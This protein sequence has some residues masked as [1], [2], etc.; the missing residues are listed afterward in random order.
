[1]S[2]ESNTGATEANNAPASPD[3]NGSDKPNNVRDLEPWAQKLISD[4][5]SEAADYR[6]R[7]RET[8][9]AKAALEAELNEL[10]PQYQ[11]LST[12]MEDLRLGSTKLEVA[13]DA[14][15]GGEQAVLFADRLRGTTREELQADA[16]K[17]LK[18]FQQPNNR[19]ATDPTQ[20]LGSAP[21]P[22]ID[23][24]MGDFFTQQLG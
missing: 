20:G 24:I 6:T 23:E 12:E 15:L 8:A 5:R 16:E 2:E 14:G 21:K 10:K 22:T 7:L 4:T 1:M 17:A 11:T 19:S 18:L 13:L 9:E 3:G